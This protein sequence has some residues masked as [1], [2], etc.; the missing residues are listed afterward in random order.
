MR[1][2]NLPALLF[3]ALGVWLI[4]F[5]MTFGYG[6]HLVGTSDIVSGILLIIFGFFSL[7][8]C[9]WSGW[10]SGLIGVWLQMAPLIFWAPL[11]LMYFN[12]TLVGAIAIVL[13]FFLN[14]KREAINL[15]EIPSGW[16]YNPSGWAHRIPTVCLAM[17]C[18][19]FARYMAAYQLGYID[20]IWDPF[21]NEGTLHVITSKISK[22][23]P[24]SDAGVGA[25]G[26]TL[27]FLLGWQ[28]SARRWASMPWLV[29]AFAFLII[30]VGAASI[31]L[32]ILQP[33]IVGAWCSWCLTTAVCMLL[34]IIFTAGELVAVLQF[35]IE[36]R[37]KGESVW[38]IFW[39]GG[40]S[41]PVARSVKP[42][43]RKKGG[44]G[45]GFTLSWNL[46]V[47]FVLGIWLMASPS[48][49]GIVGGLATG[50]FVL[51]PLIAAFSMIALAEVF[52]IVRLA[53]LFF[54]SGLII[55]PLFVTDPNTLGVVNNLIVGGVVIVLAFYKGRVSERYGEWERMIF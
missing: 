16:S 10:A 55:M 21:F 5:P 42:R 38:Q 3:G 27:E 51:G 36:T 44:L 40:T 9:N 49:F 43:E 17:L 12:D 24:V 2:K 28:G 53:N 47:S 13:S 1:E 32:I 54:G 11:S 45:W 19:F 4:A 41:A 48:N 23:F 15:T 6:G 26:Y 31:A 50:N 7:T 22:D 34:M 29:L 52:R 33:V 37:R 39:K 20:R 18:W 14:K 8:S 35:L 46:V 30:P 25:F